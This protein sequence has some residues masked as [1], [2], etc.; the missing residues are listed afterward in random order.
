MI[1]NR[2][3]YHPI[4]NLVLG[5]CFIL[6]CQSSFAQAIEKSYL[7]TDKDIYAPNDTIWFKGYVFD[8]NNKLSDKSV[9]FHVLLTNSEG[10]KIS[11]T[12]WPILQGLVDGFIVPPNDIREGAYKILATSGQMIGAPANLAFNKQLFIQTELADE[13]TLLAFPAFD[14]FEAESK[15]QIDIFTQLSSSKVASNIRLDYEL[16]VDETLSKKGRLRTSEEGKVVLN[17]DKIKVPQRSLQLIINSE[18][19]SL[20]RPVKLSLPIKIPSQI[21]LQLLPEGG[22]L[23]Q[24]VPNKVAFK[25]VDQNG[26]PFDFKGVLM[27]GDIPLDTIR[28]F[29]KGMGSFMLNPNKN[30]YSVMLMGEGIVPRSYPLVMAANTGVALSVVK[31][32]VDQDLIRLL[33]HES[34]VGESAR[35]KLSQFD[36]TI[37]EFETKLM[38][39]QYFELPATMFEDGIIIITVYDQ[40]NVPLAQRL[41]FIHSDNVLN[42]IIK[43]DKTVYEARDLVNLELKITDAEGNPVEGNFTVSAIDIEKAKSPGEES[44]NLPAQILLSSSLNGTIPTPNFYFSDHKMASEALGL[45]MLTNGWRKYRSSTLDDPEA[46]LGSLLKNNNRKRRLN[47]RSVQFVPMNNGGL[48]SFDTDTAGVFRIPSEVIKYKGDSFFILSN[49]QNAKDKFSLILNEPQRLT[50]IESQKDM[51]KT[52]GKISFSDANMI[53]QKEHKPTTDRFQN[54]ILLNS[55]E[56]EAK[57][58]PTGACELQDY[59]FEDPWTTKMADEI[60]MSDLYII[61]L[62]KQVSSEVYEFGDVGS[63]LI[64]QDALLSNITFSKRSREKVPFRIQIN[65]EPIERSELE[66]IPGALP[67]P[68]YYVAMFTLE[69]IDLS[70]LESISINRDF[71]LVPSPKFKEH[72]YPIIQ[73]NTINDQVIF[74]KRFNNR[75]FHAAY[76]NYTREFYSPKYVTEKQKNNP[77]P[78][79]RTT[80][81]WQA[82]VTTDE[83]GEA[84]ISYYN[85]DRPNK[86]QITVEGVDI[87]SRMGFSQMTY[88]VIENEEN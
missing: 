8:Q 50:K 10:E 71:R 25:A 21:D 5:L 22:N 40:E 81:F 47:G 69:R 31:G 13:L 12:S 19:K 75:F 26:K 38:P 18:D 30:R 82:N 60:D 55:V 45:V 36:K 52:L 15:N 66:L 51:V 49:N 27:Q 14:I 7:R 32:K 28:S 68:G 6:V 86:I 37:K 23:I 42:T 63:G 88:R 56:V 46:I 35:I 34:M 59:H 83:N 1:Y 24:G 67:V 73:I 85:A 80:I 41:H 43:T 3:P 62:L 9:A 20:S 79:L 76:T 44:P 70:N 74:K 57:G 29:Y 2:L 16:W 33:P 48:Q 87:Q 61:S 84:T 58:L 4:L 53:Y 11:D 39:R 17:L 65:C 77:V 64:Y 54:T 72:I 78:D